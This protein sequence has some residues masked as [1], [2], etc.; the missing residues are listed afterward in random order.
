M[1][2]LIPILG[3]VAQFAPDII[4]AFSGDDSGK[5]KMLKA[6]GSVAKKLT[7]LDSEKDAVDAISGSPELQLEFKKALMEDSHV[8]EKMRYADR[9]GARDMYKHSHQQQDKIATSVMSH[10]LWMV[11]ALVGAN[12]AIMVWVPNDYAAA[13]QGVGT[14]I[15]MVINALLKER[16]DVV[17][18]FFGS[19][20]GSKLKDNKK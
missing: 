15:G 5:D 12:V 10:N 11:L 7:G 13:M 20:M 19:S 3:A 17:G 14:L 6:A 18:F 4:D 1:I 9:A 8:A 2:P 16:Q